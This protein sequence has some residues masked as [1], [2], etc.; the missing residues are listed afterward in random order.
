MYKLIKIKN[1]SCKGCIYYNPGICIRPAHENRK[2]IIEQTDSKEEYYIFVKN[3][4]L[5]QKI[6]I[7]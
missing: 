3:T 6:I 5:N 4:D 2:C 7:L 1:S